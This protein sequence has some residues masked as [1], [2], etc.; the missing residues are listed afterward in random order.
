MR[1]LVIEDE[2]AI[3]DFVQRGL[4]AEG[5]DVECVHDGVEGEHRAL[6]GFDLIVL[7]VMLP[8]RSGLEIVRT[9]RASGASTPVIMLTARGDVADRVAGLD[10]GATD[11][12]VKPFAFSELAA[13]VRT[14]LRGP[15]PESTVLRVGELECDRLRRRVVHAGREVVL[16]PRE[17]DL[18]AYLMSHAG[19]VLSRDRLLS[20]V[21]GFDFDP[22][23]NV[24]EVYVGYLRRKLTAGGE[25]SPIETVRSVG[26]RL[27][28]T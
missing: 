4:A 27:R 16:S 7:D 23:T 24:V 28:A 3:A 6:E 8:G 9:M 22:Q 10:A 19:Q 14:H 25:D 2:P 18:L 1:I 11:Y 5:H 13:R 12:V 15:G 20:G 26:Y 17:M 21:W